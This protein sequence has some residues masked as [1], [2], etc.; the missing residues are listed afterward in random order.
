MVI[1]STEI[2]TILNGNQ[3][4]IPTLKSFSSSITHRTKPSFHP[5]TFSSFSTT[6]LLLY[7]AG[8]LYFLNDF[9]LRYTLSLYIWDFLYSTRF[10]FFFWF[11]YF[12]NIGNSFILSFQNPLKL[13]LWGDFPHMPLCS[14]H[15][16]LTLTLNELSPLTCV[17][18]YVLR[19]VW[20]FATP[21]T[22]A[23]QAPLSMEFSR[24]EYWSGLPCPSPGT[25]PIQGP[26]WHLLRLLHQ[27]AS[28]LPLAPPGKLLLKHS[29][30]WLAQ[31]S[32]SV[33]FKSY[34]YC[35]IIELNHLTFIVFAS[36]LLIDMKLLS[37]T[38]LNH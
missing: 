8:I 26:N 12:L 17:C 24:Q 3:I 31:S 23:C 4:I 33:I 7:A 20:L 10:F 22:V 9:I 35:L 27:Y 1:T 29:K 5:M 19:H 28:S 6:C 37:M 16:K 38:L 36:M 2:E 32:C 15:D 14:R 21:W 13:L 11:F 30:Q 18:V 25:F 34:K